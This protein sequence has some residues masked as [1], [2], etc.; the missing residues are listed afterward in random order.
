MPRSDLPFGSEFSPAQIDLPLLLKLAHKHGADSK[1]FEDAVRNRY[2]TKHKTSDYNKRKLANN[3]KLSLRD[4]VV[5][6]R[7]AANRL[8][9]ALQLCALRYLGSRTGENVHPGRALAERREASPARWSA[10]SQGLEQLVDP[11]VARAGCFWREPGLHQER[12]GATTAS[13]VI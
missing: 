7:G 3:T 12:G 4:L 10:R 13:T 8:G 11:Q 1:A 6:R 9:L 5:I 2:F